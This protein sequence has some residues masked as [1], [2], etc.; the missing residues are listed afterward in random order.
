MIVD[1]NFLRKLNLYYQ[2]LSRK[3]QIL[4]SMNVK[5]KR[6]DNELEKS[7]KKL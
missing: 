3:D 4:Y 6:S 5:K 1:S 7:T 2:Y